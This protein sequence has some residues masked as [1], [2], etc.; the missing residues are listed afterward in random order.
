MDPLCYFQYLEKK[1]L[2]KEE[3]K[4]IVLRLITSAKIVQN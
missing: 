4:D 2:K 3:R 1:E